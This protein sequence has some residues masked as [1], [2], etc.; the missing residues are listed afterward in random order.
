VSPGNVSTGVYVYA[1]AGSQAYS[2]TVNG[3]QYAFASAIHDGRTVVG[4]NIQLAPGK[5]SELVIEFLGKKNT[6]TAVSLEHTP[7]S[8]PASTSIDDYLDCRA[9]QPQDGAV[10]G[11]LGPALRKPVL[12]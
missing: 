1:P 11:A 5:S 2:V 9:V 12:G 7:M 3:T 8:S 4:I 6:S 10:S